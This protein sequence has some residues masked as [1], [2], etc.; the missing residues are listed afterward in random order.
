[1][2]KPFSATAVAWVFTVVVWTAAIGQAHRWERN[3]VLVQDVGVYYMYLP[4]TFIYNDLGDMSYTDAG[5]LKYHPEQPRWGLV[6]MPNGRTTVK[7]AFGMA[8]AYAPWFALAHLTARWEG[9]SVAGFSDG[10]SQPYQRWLSL[11]CMA[12]AL[13]GLWLL[14]GELRHYFSDR[15]AALTL[16]LI[17][18]ATNLLNYGTY[19]ATMSHGTLFLLNVLLLRNTRRWYDTG[20]GRYAVGVGFWLG[21]QVLVRPSEL[22][23]GAVPLL[24][25]LSSAAAWR[26][27]PRWWWAHR[28]QV[29]GAALAL[30]LVAGTLPLYWKVWGGSWTTDFYPGENFNF[31]HPHILEGLFSARKGW[32]VYTPVMALALLGLGWV[33]RYVPAAAPVLWLLLPVALYIIYSWWDWGYGGSFSGRPHISLYPLLGLSLAAFWQRWLPAAPG[34]WGRTGLLTLGLTALVTLNL[35]QTWQYYRGVLNCCETTWAS[36]RQHFFWLDWPQP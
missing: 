9:F 14:G 30:V 16:L 36:Y 1:M 19:E 22:L 20:Q 13:L 6:A 2:R 8:V 17:G 24:W 27:R 34:H 11:G 10:F 33:R 4:A 23:M 18:L 7:F 26:A 35:L 31:A 28:A 5:R 3:E 12:Y 29:L 25:G 21:L 32:L 15:V